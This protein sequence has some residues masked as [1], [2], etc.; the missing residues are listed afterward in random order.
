MQLPTQDLDTLFESAIQGLSPD[1]LEKDREFKALIRSRKIKTPLQLLRVVLLYCGLDQSLREVA[2]N[3]SLLYEKITESSI[4]ERLQSCGPWIKVLIAEMLNASDFEQLLEKRRWLVFDGTTIQGPGAKGTHYRLHLGMDLRTLQLTHI[5]ITDKHVG[6]SLSLFELEPSD[7]VLAD[8]GFFYQQPMLHTVDKGA[9]LVIRFHYTSVILEDTCGQKLN[10]IEYLKQNETI[11]SLTIPV[12]IAGL[13]NSRKLSGWIHAY[14]LPEQQAN[15]SRC[16]H[17]KKHSKKSKTPSDNTLY[18]CGWVL[19]FTTISPDKLDSKTI[20]DLYRVRWQ[21]E[22]VIKRFKSL[23]NLDKL[24]AGQGSVLSDVW[25]H[26]KM[27]YI[28]LIDRETHKLTKQ[29]NIGL[30]SE[31]VLTPWRIYKLLKQQFAPKIS[32]SMY[33]TTEAWN[34][35]LDVLR[36]R[37]RRRVLQVIPVEALFL[38]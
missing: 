11:E 6:E 3:Y 28:L 30:E 13:K 15:K 10:I 26:G 12:N 5:K 25:L 8:R 18:M 22:L 14:K 17:R 27:L 36:E 24:R 32:G 35:A 31:R 33:W 16:S 29:Y 23:L 1:V 2:A 4:H 20:S 37:K 19:V 34:D 38:N 9:D 7:V 21:I